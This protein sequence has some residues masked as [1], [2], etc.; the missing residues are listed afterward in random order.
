MGDKILDCSFM[1]DEAFEKVRRGLELHKYGELVGERSVFGCITKK[2]MKWLTKSLRYTDKGTLIK[3]GILGAGAV[4]VGSKIKKL[5]GEHKE[6]I[7]QK[8]SSKEET[9]EES[10]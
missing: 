6:E 7:I 2:G 5:W 4:W 10:E 8:L 1:T 3:G 9:E